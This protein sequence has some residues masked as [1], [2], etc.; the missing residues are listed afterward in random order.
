MPYPEVLP[1]AYPPDADYENQAYEVPGTKRSGQ[2][3]HYRNSAFPFLT[4]NSPEAFQNLVEFFDSGRGRVPAKHPLLGRRPVLSR[5]PLKLADHYVWLDWETVDIRRRYVGSGLRKLFDDGVVGGRELPV[6]G[7]YSPN[8]PEWQLVDLATHAY[9]LVSVSLYDTLGKDTVEFIVNHTEMTIICV[10]PAHIPTL[11][12]LAPQLSYLKVIVSMDVL[13]AEE[14]NILT[15][16]G[17]SVGIKVMNLAEMEA[18]GKAN[19]KP[20]TYPSSDAVANICYTSGTTG[21]PKG[22]V[23]SHGM[24]ANA[25]N[26]QLFGH[27]YGDGVLPLSLAFLP[28]AHCYGRM[29]ELVTMASGGSIG[30]WSGD[31]L[32]LLEDLQILKPNVFPAVPRVLNRIVQAGMAA[33]K[34]PGVKGALFRRALAA[35]MERL[36]ATGDF[37]HPLWDRLVFNKIKKVI[38]GN[39]VLI[40]SGSAPMSA[41]AIDFLKV[42]CCCQVLE[43]YGSTE[44]MGTA[45]KGWWSDKKAAGTVG[46]P[47]CNT[48]IKLVD[49]VAM[50]YTSEDKPYPRGEICTR[51]DGCFKYYYKDEKSTREAIDEEGWQHT[52][53]VGQIDENG[54]LV[55]IDR[56][57]NIMKLSQGEYVALERVEAL[58][59]ACPIILQLYAHGDSLQSYLLGV[60][61]P[62]PAQ[63][64]E[65]TSKIWGKPVSSTDQAALN[66]AIKDPAVYQTILDMMNTHAR[67][68]GLNGFETIKRIH[69]SN[70]LL[71]IDG[72]YITP[73]LKLKRK[74]VYERFKKELDALYTLPEPSSSKTAKL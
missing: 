28:L 47:Q 55:I 65:I 1:V 38:G 33:T 21:N 43:G 51:S 3:G 54:R 45:T 49:V 42:A 4:L 11:L 41:D 2:T 31:P 36:R 25:V 9:E 46:P 13:A 67:K 60:V 7:I 62:D 72:G 12:K 39:V 66:Q 57:K 59:S 69:L 19:L 44:N 37:T 15:V 6:V 5:N 10:A 24:V 74:A 53:D 26:A 14:M 61:I 63:L 22:V 8:C 18:I 70:E 16:W 40:S 35:K 20:V 32:L 50:G 29:S 71:T 48:E 34:L 56:V 68:A 52:G 64:A 73:T 23:M 17:E 30:Y 58:Y 27:N